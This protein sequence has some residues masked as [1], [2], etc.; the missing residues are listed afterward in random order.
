MKT[1]SKGKAPL[2]SKALSAAALSLAL[3]SYCPGQSRGKPLSKRIFAAN[4]SFKIGKS[5]CFDS[6]VASLTIRMKWLVVALLISMVLWGG[7][8]AGSVYM[9]NDGTDA[10]F[11]ASPR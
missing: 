1:V 2:Y 5:R 7:L 8:I 11:T 4:H 9:F 3:A 6:E 10:A